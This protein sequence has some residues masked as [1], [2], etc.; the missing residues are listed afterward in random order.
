MRDVRLAG[1]SAEHDIGSLLAVILTYAELA[2][3][4]MGPG[5]PGRGEVETLHRAARQAAEVNA[6][7]LLAASAVTSPGASVDLSALLVESEQLVR[8]LIGDVIVLRLA[9]DPDVPS[10]LGDRGGLER[11]LLN[12]V[13]NARDAMPAGGELRLRVRRR[14]TIGQRVELSVADTGVGMTPAVAERAF[15]R[16]FTTKAASGGTGLGLAIVHGI[17]S[18]HDGRIELETAPGRGTTVR[19]LLPASLGGAA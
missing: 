3:R 14:G 17:V 10:A 5:D 6:R 18:A 15:E 8:A 1:S 2:L 13:A 7:V 9:I 12:L 11:V 19:V 4:V 16:L